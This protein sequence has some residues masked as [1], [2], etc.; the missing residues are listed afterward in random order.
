MLVPQLDFKV[1]DLFTMT[2]EAKMPRLDNT[3]MYW[4]N[5][6]FVYLVTADTVKNVGFTLLPPSLSRFHRP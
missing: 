1:K 5:T 3:G 4:S 2:L 6:N